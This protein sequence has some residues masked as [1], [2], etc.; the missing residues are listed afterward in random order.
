MKRILKNILLSCI[1]VFTLVM[2]VGCSCSKPMNI[3]YTVS[4]GQGDKDTELKSL[5]AVVATVEKKFREP[6]DTPCYRKMKAGKNKPAFVE[7]INTQEKYQCYGSD[8]Y[9]KA[10]SG[11]V[12]ITT[13]EISK[14]IEGSIKCYEKV[15]K[16]YYKLLEKPDGISEC[17]TKDGKYFERA[18]FEA[19]EKVELSNHRVLSTKENIKSYNSEKQVVPSEKKYSLIYSFTITNKESTTIYIEA[20]DF[21]TITNGIIKEKSYSKLEITQ[22]SNMV[23]MNNRYYYQINPNSAIVL[24][25]KIQNLLNTDTINK[26]KD[27]NLNIP[28]IVK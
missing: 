3:T 6:A 27:L 22:P 10:D 16:T 1:C 26:S 5:I 24:K 2:N 7:L 21:Q 19:V 13:A 17:Y 4:S 12:V 9:K 18:T 14:C 11:Y 25:I 15:E 20:L 23:F 28:I 8:C